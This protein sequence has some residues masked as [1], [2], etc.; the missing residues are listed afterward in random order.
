ME[1]FIIYDR[2]E[3]GIP[4]Y[5]TVQENLC[6]EQGRRAAVRRTADGV[7]T[8]KTSILGVVGP[9]ASGKTA[10]AVELALRLDG[11]VVSC[12]SMQLYRGMDIGSA[13]PTDEEKRGVPHHMLDIL[14]PGET[15]S[16]ADY[17][18]QASRIV[19][20]IASRGKLPIVCG[21]TGLYFDSL[22]YQNEFGGAGA[23]KELRAELEKLSSDELW[24]RLNEV[25]AEA[26]AAIHPNN[27]RRVARALEL[28]LSTGIPKTEW[29]RRS[30]VRESRYEATIIGLDSRDREVLYRRID[31]RVGKMLDAG[32]VEEARAMRNSGQTASQAIGYKELWDY[33]DGR[34]TLEEAAARIRLATRH[35]AKRQLTWFRRNPAIRWVYI[36]E[37]KTVDEIVNFLENIFLFPQFCD[38][39]KRIN[40]F[41]GY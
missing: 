10:L 27:R 30:R 1:K 38:K 8:E 22:L 2:Y 13:K 41:Y 17:V 24:R 40:N 12:D 26:A 35:Y 39:I 25:D 29:D 32:L 11:E 23:D 14:D 36:D 5:Y 21:G 4:I 7:M 34:E 6:P 16:C 9:T 33:L 3:S 18:A 20:D 37:H 19:D 28:Y 15:F 31:A